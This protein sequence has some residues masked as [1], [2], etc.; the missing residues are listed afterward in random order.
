[1]EKMQFG[2]VRGQIL[3]DVGLSLFEEFQGVMSVFQGKVTDPL[4]ITNNV[5][6]T[7]VYRPSRIMHHCLSNNRSWAFEIHGPQNGV[8]IYTEKPFVHNNIYI[9]V[10][11]RSIKNGGWA[12]T[13]DNTICF[14]SM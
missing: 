14:R 6:D 2:G 7:L 4:D 5:S 9:Y 10:N 13:W 1:M 11:R 8:D 12:L 3:S